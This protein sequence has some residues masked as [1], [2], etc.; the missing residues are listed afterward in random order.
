MKKIVSLLLTAL[1][2]CGVLIPVSAAPQAQ[3]KVSSAEARPGDT[4]SVKVIIENNPGFCYLKVNYSYDANALTLKSID[5]GTVST[6][7]FTVTEKSVLWDS[8][9]NATG[10]GTLCTLTFTVKT[11]AEGNFDIRISVVECYNYDEAAVALLGGSGKI[12]VTKPQEPEKKI[13]LGDVNL[14]GRVGTEDARLCLRRA[15]GLETYPKGSDEFIA[16]DIDR[17]QNVSTGDARHILRGAIGL[18]NPDTW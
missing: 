7:A 2:L 10:A 12:T 14:D 6:D 17:N 15:I 13:K 8:D 16:C 3:L 5:N 9:R 1:L 4:V 11:G 18:E